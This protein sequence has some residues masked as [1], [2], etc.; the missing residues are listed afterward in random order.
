MSKTVSDRI[1]PFYTTKG[2]GKGTGMGLATVLGV[3]Q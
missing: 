2:V 3:L 1:F